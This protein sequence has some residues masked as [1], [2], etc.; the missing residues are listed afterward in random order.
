MGARL[1]Y[2]TWETVEKKPVFPIGD[3]LKGSMSV[4]KWA[5]DH[6]GEG[7]VYACSFGAEGMV[8]IDL[9]SRVK[10]NAKVVFLD[11][12]LHFKETYD[13]IEQVKKRYPDLRI[14]MLEPDL[15][16]EEQANRHGD[17][18]WERNPNLCCHIRKIVPL[19]R[20]L[21]Q[22]TAWI[23]GLRRDQSPTRRFTQ[24]LNQD[25]RFQAV[26]VCPLIHW[27]WEDVWDYIREKDLPYN[28]LHDRG[29][30][31]IGCD[32]CTRPVAEGED[33]RAGRWTGIQK[34]ECGLH[35]NP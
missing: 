13:V 8:L 26:K 12:D 21:S 31:S 29:Y 4:L 10:P 17:A 20:A 11:T 19:E 16:L 14:D 34:T 6:Y 22:V 25:R 23:S 3:P 15:T 5:F 32:K 33:S 18:L 28:L 1:T 24:F 35:V 9:I 30:P 7:L 27:T 2:E